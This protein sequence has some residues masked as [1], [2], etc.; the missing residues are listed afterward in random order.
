MKGFIS[1][2]ILVNSNVKRSF[3]AINKTYKLQEKI[4]KNILKIRAKYIDEY[5]SIAYKIMDIYKIIEHIP[6]NNVF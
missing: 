2:N 5:H 6:P 3:S 1:R 4:P